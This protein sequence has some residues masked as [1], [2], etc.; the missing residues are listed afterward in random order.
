MVAVVLLVMLELGQG[1][2]LLYLL[3]APSLLVVLVDKVLFPSQQALVVML[4]PPRGHLLTPTHP[5][6][7]GGP[8]TRAFHLGP[9][10][11]QKVPHSSLNSFDVCLAHR[12]QLWRPEREPVSFAALSLGPSPGHSTQ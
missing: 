12:H 11:A 4:L 3:V 8:V 7:P 6:P 1:R 2:V 10:A 9:S 5:P